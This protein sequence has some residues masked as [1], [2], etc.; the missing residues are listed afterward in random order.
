VIAGLGTDLIALARIS[1]AQQRSHNRF[2]RKILGDLEYAVW[3]Q[4]QNRHPEA[5]ISYLAS[6]FA[7]K[8]AFA[9]ACG[10]GLRMPLSWQGIQTLNDV[11]GRPYL[12]LDAPICAWLK[13]RSYQAHVA[14][15]DERDHALA[16]VI[17]EMIGNAV[18]SV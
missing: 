17:L 2:A 6:R 9:K 1:R 12:Q 7:A 18:E 8:E 3:M 11:F 4:R 16:V 10:L 14:L 5:G 15:T 13:E